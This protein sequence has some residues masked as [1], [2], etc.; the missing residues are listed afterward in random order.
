MW[1]YPRKPNGEIRYFDTT[2]TLND[3]TIYKGST[4]HRYVSL[5]VDLIDGAI[6]KFNVIPVTHVK[7]ISAFTWY[8][9]HK[10]GKCPIYDYLTIKHYL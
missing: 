5:N 4:K 8:T 9:L 10:D 7:G 6:Y 3:T 2:I 1:F